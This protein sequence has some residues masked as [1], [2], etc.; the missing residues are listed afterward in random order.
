MNRQSGFSLLEMMIV[1]GIMGIL[2]TM[3]VPRLRKKG[4]STR[5]VRGTIPASTVSTLSF[6]NYGKSKVEIDV[7]IYGQNVVLGVSDGGDSQAAATYYDKDVFGL[8]M[9]S[10]GGKCQMTVPFSSDLTCT[11]TSGNSVCSNSTKELDSRK[12]MSLGF[13]VQKA[14]GAVNG[15]RNFEYYGWHVQPH[16]TRRSDHVVWYEIIVKD[17]DG[18]GHLVGSVWGYEDVGN[19]AFSI[20]INGGEPF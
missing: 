13:G 7:K 3:M 16:Q 10:P 4:P 6:V 18:G 20:P 19:A 17:P 1:V 12:G 5:V 8:C 14:H 11:V 2:A 9:Y 15:L